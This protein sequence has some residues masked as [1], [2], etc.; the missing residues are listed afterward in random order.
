MSF[1]SKLSALAGH[2]NP[3]VMGL[4]LCMIY[5]YQLALVVLM[6]SGTT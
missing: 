3:Y 4:R 5:V 1:A 2:S 6:A